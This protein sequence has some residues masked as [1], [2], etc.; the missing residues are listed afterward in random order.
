VLEA[1]RAA[2]PARQPLLT[3]DDR[4]FLHRPN[5]VLQLLD[6]DRAKKVRV[7]PRVGIA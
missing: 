4:P 3:V 6:H 2:L 7:M 1:L 5:R